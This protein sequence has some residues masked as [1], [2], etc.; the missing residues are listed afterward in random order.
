MKMFEGDA[1]TCAVRQKS[2]C[3]EADAAD[4]R[5]VAAKLGVDFFVFNYKDVFRQEVIERF[6]KCYARGETPNPCIDCNKYVKFGELFRHLT[7]YECDMFA[8]GHYARISRD[9][10]S[11]R[12]LLRKAVDTAKD[13]TYFLYNLT[14]EQ[15]ARTRFPVGELTKR[16]VREI[17][18][19]QGFITARKPESQDICFVPDGNY[20]SFIEAHT[21][22][23]MRQGDFVDA[24]G[25][26]IGRHGGSMRYT[27]GQRRGIGVGGFSKPMYVVSIDAVNNTVRLGEESELYSRRLLARDINWIAL[28]GLTSPIKAHAQIRYNSTPQPA[29]LHPV[30][31]N[32]VMVDFSISQRAI[33]SGQSVV[34]YDGDVTI[35][36]GTICTA[37]S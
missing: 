11:G 26:V 13:Q 23:A 20:M 29:T 7:A 1:Q 18:E 22:G 25:N 14:Q 28:S 4:A 37:E 2:C 19:T 5:A 12:W 24:T 34:F 9:Q 31:D 33:A 3:S 17:A 30:G 16:E 32:E 15:L 8:T 6:V 21:G 27:I 36:G 10:G 35:G